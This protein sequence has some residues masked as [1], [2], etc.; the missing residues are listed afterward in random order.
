[1]S[2][3]FFWM[4]TIAGVGLLSTTGCSRFLEPPTGASAL[5]LSAGPV[6]ASSKPDGANT[7]GGTTNGLTPET[8][9]NNVDRI[10][11]FMRQALNN[12]SGHAGDNNTQPVTPPAGSKGWLSIFPLPQPLSGGYQPQESEIQ[13]RLLLAD[14]IG[15]AFGTTE[16]WDM[17]TAIGKPNA[18]FQSFVGEGILLTGGTDKSWLTDS[19][20]SQRAQRAVGIHTCLIAR[21]NAFGRPV[22]IWLKGPD[23]APY[24]K[25]SLPNPYFREAVWLAVPDLDATGSEPKIHL[26][27]LPLDGL[28]SRCSIPEEAIQWRICGKLGPDGIGSTKV[29]AGMKNECNVTVLPTGTY[30][31]TSELPFCTEAP[32]GQGK[33]TCNFGQG[34]PT[35]NAIE[36]RLAARDWHLIY[37]CCAQ[38]AGQGVAH[39]KSPFPTR[40]IGP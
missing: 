36:T 39:C 22:P 33:W 35:Y 16:S 6:V 21:L 12:L 30:Q 13:N 4:T 20:Q 19:L 28:T 25:L 14:M 32:P 7:G 34:G 38:C 40:H 29:N 31:A 18:S 9:Y 26:Y 15:C 27:A 2:S 37:G 24:P 5:A 10:N 1:M 8:Y 17:T 11:G 23:V 3:N